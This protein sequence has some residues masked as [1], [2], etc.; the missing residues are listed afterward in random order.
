M[1]LILMDLFVCSYV[2]FCCE[3]INAVREIAIWKKLVILFY[4]TGLVYDQMWNELA[5]CPK[6][7]TVLSNRV[8]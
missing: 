5:C 4:S 2:C 8:L 1:N 6:L 7:A 3:W